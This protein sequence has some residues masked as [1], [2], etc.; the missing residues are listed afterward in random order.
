MHV[1]HSSVLSNSGLENFPKIFPLTAALQHI[2]L[3][4][5]GFAVYPPVSTM[6]HLSEGFIRQ[7]D[8]VNVL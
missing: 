2:P 5:A 8:G 4:Y 7:G 3:E 6:H 1:W